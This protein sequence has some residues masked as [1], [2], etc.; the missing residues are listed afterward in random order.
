VKARTALPV[1][2][3]VLSLSF[4]MGEGTSG[5]AQRSMRPPRFTT[6]PARLG[7]NPGHRSAPVAPT[8]GPNVN[9]SDRPDA[10]SETSVAIDP[11]D[12]TH[13]LAGVNNLYEQDS[14][15]AKVY[16]SFDS[17]A[18]WT[19]TL[20]IPAGFCYDTWLDFGSD[21]TAYLA[22][23]CLDQRV[24]VKQPGS[25]AWVNLKLANAGGLPDRDMVVT[26]RSATSPFEGSAYIGYDDSLEGDGNVA[27]VM[28]SRDGLV[29]LQSDP[30]ND[31]NLTI[32]VNAAVAAD[33]TVYA[34][35]ED[36]DNRR[37]WVDKSTDG[38][39]TW[40]T[41]HVVHRYRLATESFFI[42]IP[43]QPERGIVPMP[44]SDV[45]PSG[46]PHAGRLYVTY[47]DQSKHGSDTDVFVRYSDNRGATWSGEKK[48]NDDRVG[49]WQF[50]P[51]IT[52]MP[53]GTVGVSFYD[54]RNDATNGKTDRYVA[55]SRDGARWTR[56][57]KVTTAMSDETNS[58]DGNDYGDYQAIDGAVGLVQLAWTD[59]RQPGTQAEDLFSAYVKL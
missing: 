14:L 26:D 44:F 32:G 18:T 24:A 1:V 48:V 9:V 7:S 30:I 23:E 55:F 41:D 50:H 52:V 17:G 4:A 8:P 46:T 42:S 22:Y 39:A 49:A 6:I 21:G 25:S 45:S 28:Y 54:T 33:G 59:S 12:P 3:F 13:I 29:W 40:S 37:I 47:T 31:A 16:E 58:P 38:G 34:V 43:P 20:A 10:Q 53:N 35:W 2:L 36:I 51:S 5:A 27:H 56:N 11:T 57:L 19:D 15:T